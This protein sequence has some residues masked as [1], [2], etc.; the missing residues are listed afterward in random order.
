MT[1][2]IVKKG[3]C[4][5]LKNLSRRQGEIPSLPYQQAILWAT[6]IREGTGRQDGTIHVSR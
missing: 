1:G 6:S 5:L 3:D 4:R 2:K